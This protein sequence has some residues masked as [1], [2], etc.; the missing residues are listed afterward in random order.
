MFFYYSSNHL[1]SAQQN[2]C[3]ILKL[4]NIHNFFH[5]WLL[6]VKFVFYRLSLFWIP[7][8][9]HSIFVF[10]CSYNFLMS[11]QKFFWLTKIK[12]LPC[13]KCL[14]ILEWKADLKT[15]V[16]YKCRVQSCQPISIFCLWETFK[17]ICILVFQ[18][19]Q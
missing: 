15:F 18:I 3:E 8:S 1:I 2:N 6:L 13:Q 14:S 4:Q 11:N 16:T 10:T 17:L 9:A 19:M 5:Y 12:C 7:L